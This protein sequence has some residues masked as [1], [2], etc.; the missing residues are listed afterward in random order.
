M[1][2]MLMMPGMRKADAEKF[3]AWSRADLQAHITYMKKLNTA[4][5]ATG[6]LVRAEGLDMP[7][8]AVTVRAGEDGRPVTDGVF[9]ESKEFLMGW[10]IIDVESQRAYAIAAQASAAP[11]VRGAPLNMLI[12]VRQIPPAPPDELP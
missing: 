8:R 12:E 2:Y 9:P 11:G 7:E 6:E 5:F 1:K 4:L 3:A 10:W